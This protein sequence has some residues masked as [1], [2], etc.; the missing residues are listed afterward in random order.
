MKM[1]FVMMNLSFSFF[2]SANLEHSS[3]LGAPPAA[4]KISI[5]HGCFQEIQVLGCNHPRDG[6]EEFNTCV[7]DRSD[8]LTPV[9]KTF[10]E[11]LYGKKS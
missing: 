6:R 8:D 7:R 3:G 5:S 9:C 4:E 2:A 10:F 11:K 1:F